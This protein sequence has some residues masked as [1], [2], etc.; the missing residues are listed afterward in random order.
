MFKGEMEIGSW[1][2]R[3]FVLS[4]DALDVYGGEGFLVVEVFCSKWRWSKILGSGGLLFKVE[5]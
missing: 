3:S 1:E 4:G 2:W 5:M